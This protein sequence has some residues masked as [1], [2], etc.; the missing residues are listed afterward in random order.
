MFPPFNTWFLYLYATSVSF[1][2]LPWKLKTRCCNAAPMRTFDP[3]RSVVND[4]G[5]NE[6][7]VDG[8]V[9]CLTVCSINRKDLTRKERLRRFTADFGTR[10][11]PL[12]I[13]ASMYRSNSCTYSGEYCI[14]E[15]VYMI[16]ANQE[17]IPLERSSWSTTR[18]SVIF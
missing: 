7:T 13:V 9:L 18:V 14:V 17:G 8:I 15:F 3:L 16:E 2:T 12:L 1:R 10:C 5:P 11:R 4:Q 6:C